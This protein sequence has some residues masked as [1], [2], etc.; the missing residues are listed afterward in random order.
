MAERMAGALV[1]LLADSLAAM[2]AA[3]LV[4]LSVVRTV[5]DW[6]GG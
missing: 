6:V 4:E 3:V 2:T 5:V 1:E